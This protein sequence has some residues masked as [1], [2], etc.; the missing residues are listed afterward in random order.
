[1]TDERRGICR[2]DNPLLLITDHK[3]NAVEDIFSVLQ[4]VARDIDILSSTNIPKN[5]RTPGTEP[6]RPTTGSSL[7]YNNDAYSKYKDKI[8]IRTG[9]FR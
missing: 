6:E 5:V 4:F 2:Y 8:G 9:R 3:I 7:L 1:V